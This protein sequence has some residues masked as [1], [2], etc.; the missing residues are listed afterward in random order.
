VPF[1]VGH[2]I[3]AGRWV[4]I[5]LHSRGVTSLLKIA[6]GAA[7]IGVILTSAG[8]ASV[9]VGGPISVLATQVATP[10]VRGWPIIASALAVLFRFSHDRVWQNP[11]SHAAAGLLFAEAMI[12]GFWLA[13]AVFPPGS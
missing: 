8:A 3:L 13:A 2:A 6:T 10:L 5:V 1:G 12:A 7:A 4:L 9:V 11:V